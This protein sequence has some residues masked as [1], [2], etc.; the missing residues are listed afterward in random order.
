MVR[1]VHAQAKC[2]FG[3]TEAEENYITALKSPEAGTEK[4]SGRAVCRIIVIASR[5]GVEAMDLI[6]HVTL[7]VYEMSFQTA[8]GEV[9][10][11]PHVIV[12]HVIGKTLHDHDLL[13]RSVF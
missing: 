5:V 2:A 7:Y 10:G 4:A 9:A 1:I 11:G 12:A 6:H 3:G 13:R 8:V